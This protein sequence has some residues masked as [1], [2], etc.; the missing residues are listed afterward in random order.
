MPQ[1][2][3]DMIQKKLCSCMRNMNSLLRSFVSAKYGEWAL[4]LS[5]MKGVKSGADWQRYCF[6]MMVL[7]FMQVVWVTISAWYDI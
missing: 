4:Q 2:I 5:T 1:D 6:D 7:I 3:L